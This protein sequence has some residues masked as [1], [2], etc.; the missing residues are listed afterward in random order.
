MMMNVSN[1]VG[2]HRRALLIGIDDYSAYDAAAGNPAGASDLRGARNDIRVY[3]QIALA[4]GIG[5]GDI[6]VLA[7][8]PIPAAELGVGDSRPAT[9]SEIEHGAHWLA[10]SGGRAIMSFSGHG[11]VTDD[12]ELL[13]CPADLAGDA[14]NAMPLN[15]LAHML[16][17]AEAGQNVT[18]FIDACHAGASSDEHHNG[19][20]RRS[21]RGREVS[22]SPSRMQM[23]NG[24]H[25]A[26][27]LA[28]SAAHQSSVEAPFAGVW[29]GAFTWAVRTVLER[30]TTRMSM[31]DAYVDI[32]Y[33]NLAARTRAVLDALTFEQRPEFDG[34]SALK[35]L[36]LFRRVD[37]LAEGG[38][39]DKATG[40][41]I[42][43]ELPPTIS[44]F[45]VFE[46]VE[47]TLEEGV[48][49]FVL[50][51]LDNFVPNAS[52]D[53]WV[54]NRQYWYTFNQA[55]LPNDF[56]LRR[57]WPSAD[58]SVPSNAVD[59]PRPVYDPNAAAP[60]IPFYKVSL[61]QGSGPSTVGDM[62]ISPAQKWF[63]QSDPF[64]ID[65][66]TDRLF[67]NRVTS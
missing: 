4:L 62:K 47:D 44:G 29:M 14:S 34:P 19:V 37:A 42:D 30:W 52:Q 61:D 13:L 32:S 53:G 38:A 3:V 55:P 51:T 40:S 26:L 57:Y 33:A 43:R 7:S 49:G 5:P 23:P 56:R 67:F 21:L 50:A 35:S 64:T 9:N 2:T 20:A 54:K 16:Q 59:I 39:S 66:M 45:R 24:E 36:P 25:A 46:I 60:A 58:P 41:I 65:N 11:D 1:M 6:R 18:L 27:V 28:A 31:D 63:V 12:G 8:P 15:H 22:R 48:L 17:G 10:E